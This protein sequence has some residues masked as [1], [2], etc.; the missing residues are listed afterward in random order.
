[1]EDDA[2]DPFDFDLGYQPDQDNFNIGEGDAEPLFPTS[3]TTSQSFSNNPTGL[4]ISMDGDDISM[5][6]PVT[7]GQ[8]NIVY[9]SG[10]SFNPMGV[11]KTVNPM[12]FQF[13]GDLINPAALTNQQ[14]SH[15]SDMAMLNSA[16]NPAA[17]NGEALGHR[18][19][20]DSN[21]TADSLAGEDESVFDRVDTNTSSQ[22][23]ATSSPP[24][25]TRKIATGTSSR[26]ARPPPIR[27]TDNATAGPPSAGTSSNPTSAST[28][29]K[30]KNPSMHL[31]E[32]A[33][34]FDQLDCIAAANG[35]LKGKQRASVSGATENE[36]DDE[37]E[38]SDC[39][40][41]PPK[42]TAHNMI[43]KR[44]RTNLNMK[45][46]DL[47]H[48]VPSLRVAERLI[49]GAVTL[50]QCTVT[51]TYGRGLPG[52]K[53]EDGGPIEDLE[54]LQPAAKLNKAT[55]LAKAVEYIRFL[56]KRHVKAHRERDALGRQCRTLQEFWLKRGLRVP[57]QLQMQS[58]G[59]GQGQGQ[60][61][62]MQGGG[63]QG[64]NGLAG[65]QGM[66][67]SQAQQLAAQRDFQIA[68]QNHMSQYQGQGSS[69]TQYT[70]QAQQFARDQQE[71]NDYFM[72]GAVDVDDDAE[73]EARLKEE[74]EREEE[75]ILGA[76]GHEEDEKD[77]EEQPPKRSIR[78]SGRNASK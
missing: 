73:L 24:P 65:I 71:L 55:V 77:E 7:Q 60:G 30:R 66:N 27:T 20:M 9:A 64:G 11:T 62:G 41:P 42:K 3:D 18:S 15:I 25:P 14:L 76:V 5:F 23:A 72:T 45:I 2:A 36:A 68:M 16:V 58:M 50:S 37:A 22:T 26:R 75:D 19:S 57:G 4:G 40:Q 17:G 13:N 12:D 21:T 47:R 49:S 69:Q 78:R 54:G 59:Q 10:M 61:Q 8:N 35:K 63:M 32:E 48:A 44:Y 46:F 31:E 53:A 70:A 6:P 28:S 1:M 39:R 56:E 52:Q 33:Y 38:T 67:M 51:G 74:L 34:S 43:E 29:R